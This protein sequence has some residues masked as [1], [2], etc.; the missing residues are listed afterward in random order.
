MRLL[1]V[2]FFCIIGLQ[3]DVFAELSSSSC[4]FLRTASSVT[5]I[6]PEIAQLGMRYYR[7][8]TPPSSPSP[9]DQHKRQKR[10]LFGDNTSKG[11]TGTKGSVLEQ[12]VA[13]AFKDVNYTKVALLIIHN[14]D[15]MN[16]IRQNVDGNTIIRAAMREIDY[17]KLGNSLWYAAEAEFDLEY[18]ISSFINITHMDLIYEELIIKGT[19]PDWLIKSIHPDLNVQ[20]IQRTFESLKNVTQILAAVT[21]NIKRLDVYLFD[22]IQNKVL[23]PLGSV[24]QKVKNENPT[25]LDELVETILNNLSKL[26]MVKSFFFSLFS[27]IIFLFI[28]GTN[29]NKK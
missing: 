20:S 2:L 19:L 11:N 14:N 21:S 1:S 8:S 4:S 9:P 12:M 5:A 6:V 23:T 29:W 22:T 13:N 16:K 26:M 10:F 7:V 17:E 15:T 27:K 28:L 3:I 24:L 18:L 25:T